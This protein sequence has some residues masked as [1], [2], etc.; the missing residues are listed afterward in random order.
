MASLKHF[1]HLFSGLPGSQNFF[2]FLFSLTTW[3][4]KSCQNSS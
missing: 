4:P 1:P 3:S 2:N